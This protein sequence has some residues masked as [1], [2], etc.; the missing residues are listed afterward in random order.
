MR[1]FA[2]SV[3][4][5]YSYRFNWMGR[6]VVQYPQDLIALQEV[7]WATR[8]DLIVETGIAHGGSLVFYASMLHLLDGPGQVLGID[9]E[10]RSSNRQAI[11][12]HPMRSRIT[13]IEGSSIDDRVVEE[14]TRRAR[15]A[16]RVMVVLDSNHTHDH[17]LR[18]LHCYAPL[19]TRGNY[20]IVLDTAIEQLPDDAFPDR[21]WSRGNNPMTAVRAF[22]KQD[23]R[24]EIDRTIHEKIVVTVAPDGYLRRIADG[25]G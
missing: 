3:P 18:E 12:D 7:I 24:F 14:V 11:D 5:R 4:E 20:L 16:G 10:I 6:P 2:A 22:L 15:S 25:D 17:V 13:M 21:P 23:D 1:F 9:V 8:P 19:V